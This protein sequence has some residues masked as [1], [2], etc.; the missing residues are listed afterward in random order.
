[1]NT[2]NNGDTPSI[3]IKGGAGPFAAAAIA[4]VIQ[5]VLVEEQ[6]AASVPTNGRRLS[7]W[8]IAGRDEVFMPPRS[9]VT[10]ST[11]KAAPRR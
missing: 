2:S 6:V 9:S 10:N 5:Q 4:A 3:Q 8:L 7:G 11:R 1:M